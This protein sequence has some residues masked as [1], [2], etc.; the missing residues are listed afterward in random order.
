MNG[1]E[2]HFY[3]AACLVD[4]TLEQEELCPCCGTNLW[5]ENAFLSEEEKAERVKLVDEAWE[6]AKRIGLIG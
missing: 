4:V 2:P 6:S 5:Q 1:A 3:C